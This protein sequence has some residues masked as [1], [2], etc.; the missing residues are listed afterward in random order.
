M[1]S[2][3]PV[4]EPV[5]AA[6][7]VASPTALLSV[8]ATGIGY[9]IARDRWRMR[10]GRPMVSTPVAISFYSGLFVVAGALAGPLDRASDASLTAHMV[11]HVLLLTVA[12]P[13]LAFG[14]PLPTLLWV[15][16]ERGRRRAA[17]WMRR[18][19]R[20]HD[21]RFVAWV[22]I[23]LA[24]EAIVMW[25]WHLPVAY[26]AAIRD[27]VLHAL[28]HASFV[29]V[30]AAAWWS[31]A[32]GRRSRRGAAAIAALF[33]SVPGMLL[34]VAMVL[35]PNPWYPVYARGGTAAALSNQQVAGVVMWAFG[36]MAAVIAG[37]ALFA[38]WLSYEA[39]D[40]VVAPAARPVG[41][42]Q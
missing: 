29:F 42:G 16:P 12:G 25:S 36:G 6:V 3:F 23:A 7:I 27:P 13:L 41:A 11:Q 40:V 19:G 14:A 24:V 15:F 38:S 34:G 9:A 28:E 22:T 32:T 10:T 31:V 39:G 21:R 5:V 8:V 37:V 33:G 26:Q 2:S 1:H 4:A 17:A 18:L 30:S 20:V 35:A